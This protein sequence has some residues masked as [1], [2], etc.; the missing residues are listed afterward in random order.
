[1]ACQIPEPKH[2]AL[3][4]VSASSKGPEPKHAALRH[5]SAS[6]I[7]DGTVLN[8][9]ADAHIAAFQ[10]H[11]C[12]SLAPPLELPF[13]TMCSGGEVVVL[14]LKAVEQR[15][16]HIGIKIK[17]KHMFSC[18][19]N[20]AK[21]TWIAGL[22]QELGIQGGCIFERIESLGDHDAWCVVHKRR[23]VVPDAELVIAGTSCKDLS[24]A[25]KNK[26]PPGSSFSGTSVFSSPGNSVNTFLG[27]VAYLKSHKISL[28]IFENVDNLGDNTSESTSG[29]DQIEATVLDTVIQAF[30]STGLVCQPT[31]TDASVF[32]LPT[33]RRRYYISGVQAGAPRLFSF[34]KK[35]VK[36]TFTEMRALLELCPASAPC[37]SEL[38]LPDDDPAVEAMLNKRVAI[39]SKASDYNVAATIATFQGA[40]LSWAAMR[41]PKAVQESPWFSTLTMREKSAL[42]FSYAEK[43]RDVIH[44]D[45]SQSVS[46]V[47]VSHQVTDRND[48]SKHVSCCQLPGQ[49]MWLDLSQLPGN[50]VT[51]RIM[52]GREALT[53]Q[54]YPISLVPRLINTS[55]ESL[56]GDIAGNMMAA[57]V[58]LAL[59]M[60]LLASLPWTAQGGDALR[61]SDD[62]VNAA[63]ALLHTT[64]VV[65][66]PVDTNESSND[67]PKQEKRRR[68]L[69][70]RSFASE[71]PGDHL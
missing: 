25:N 69:L 10:A 50:Q 57:T 37:V 45:I 56:M 68:V 44:R 26:K 58:P 17:F 71:N 67:Q 55:T 1:M 64:N 29:A 46:R 3:R 2:A 59:I 30:E 32:G 7:L 14:V 43:E 49:T 21:I 22:L 34:D 13:C 33:E 38:A 8:R 18:E 42:A 70:R 15:L 11:G 24:K 35:S 47:R 40:G 16:N 66:L 27:L 52:L 19:A 6:S 4:N 51:P 36:D 28:L 60:S 61:S 41:F 48:E 65:Q 23:C 63:M 20:A 5:V 53:I 39:G 31:L 62:D 54:G 9:C 12:R